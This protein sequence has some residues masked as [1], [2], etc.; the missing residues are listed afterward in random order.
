MVHTKNSFAVL[1][2][3]ICLR[4]KQGTV[5]AFHMPSH[6]CAVPKAVASLI[7]LGC[8]LD[9]IWEL[10]PKKLSTPVRDF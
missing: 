8:Q 7:S 6:V 4:R 9:Y 10:K 1:P 2:H 3:R 5:T